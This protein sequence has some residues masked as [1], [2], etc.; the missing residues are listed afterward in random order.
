[1]S[2]GASIFLLVI[3]AI[4]TFAV[5]VTT[6]GF[7]INTVGVILMVAGVVGLLLSLLFWSNFSPYR[8][9]RVVDTYPEER[10]VE[11]RRIERDYP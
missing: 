8:R 4:L 1:M 5:N 11:E 9:R 6:E 10:V 7:N 2:I 3:G